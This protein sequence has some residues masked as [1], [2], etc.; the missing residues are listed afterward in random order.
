MMGRSRGIDSTTFTALDDVQQ[1]SDSAFTSAVEFTYVTTA[2]SG[3]SALRRFSAVAVTKSAMGHPA[4]RSG[5]STV[6]RGDRILAV[7]AMKWTPQKT[8]TSASVAAASCES[9]SESPR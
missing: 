4:R 9:P 6:F 8:M 2:A 7:S 1:M 3:C 5:M